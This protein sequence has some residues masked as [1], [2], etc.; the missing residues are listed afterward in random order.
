MGGAR[1]VRD[2]R[3]K[4]DERKDGDKQFPSTQGGRAPTETTRRI[5]VAALWGVG[6]TEGITMCADNGEEGGQRRSAILKTVTADG[7][8]IYLLIFRLEPRRLDRWLSNLAA[9]LKH[10]A[11]ISINT[12]IEMPPL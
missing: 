6:R 10:E 8:Y 2:P 1:H 3:C 5:V 11:A 4:I 7:D 12:P 9:Q